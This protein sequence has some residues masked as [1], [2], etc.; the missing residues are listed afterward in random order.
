LVTHPSLP[1]KSVKELI[2]LAKARPAR[3]FFSSSGAGA[4]GH[5]SGRAVQLDDRRQADARALQRE[6]AA[7]RR[8]DRR[9]VQLS[10]VSVPAVIGYVQN[11]QLRMI[12]Q[13]G[14][15][16]FQS[17]PNVPTMEE[18]GL[19]PAFVVSSGFSFPRTRRHAAPPLLT[20]ST[21]RWCRR[22]AIRRIAK[23]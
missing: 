12:A 2:A 16:R 13:C 8:S 18:A 21:R 20:S 22:C 4:V 6:P 5:L 14:A 19:P 7:R 11:R 23:H 3:F 9:H 1:V 15:A 17:I 10:F